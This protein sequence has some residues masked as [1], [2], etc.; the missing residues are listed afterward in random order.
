MLSQ[1]PA[2]VPAPPPVTPSRVRLPADIIPPVQPLVWAAPS[3]SQSLLPADEQ[4]AAMLQEPILQAL[5]HFHP[6]EY[7]EL[8]EFVS[9]TLIRHE[10]I[11]A[12]RWRTAVDARLA[13]AMTPA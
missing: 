12:A 3:L 4:E 13:E 10:L 5:L 1:G 2:P 11:E 8:L 6:A 7:R 9:L